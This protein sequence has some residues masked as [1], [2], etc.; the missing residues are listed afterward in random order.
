MIFLIQHFE[1]DFLW[2]VSLKIL[3]SGIILKPFIHVFMNY[4]VCSKMSN[5]FI[6]LFATE[7]YVIRAG[8]Q[9]MLVRIANSKDDNPTASSGAVG[10]ESVLF[11]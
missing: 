11:I 1:A 2:K 9:K 7:M 6:F 5:T 10:F 8:I 4:C 3:N